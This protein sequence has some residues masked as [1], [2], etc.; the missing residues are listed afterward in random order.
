[1]V[2]RDQVV[3]KGLSKN[4][5]KSNRG[6]NNSFCTH[7]SYIA[8]H[9]RRRLRRKNSDGKNEQNRAAVHRHVDMTNGIHLSVSM[10]IHCNPTP[11]GRIICMTDLLSSKNYRRSGTDVGEVEDG[12]RQ[13]IIR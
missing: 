11:S 12:G 4:L 10:G 1:M 6:G 13:K 5:E 7:V 3:V 2:S 9:K 8:L